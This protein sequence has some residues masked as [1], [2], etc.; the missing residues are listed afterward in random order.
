M[1][2][3]LRKIAEFIVKHFDAIANWIIAIIEKLV[4]APFPTVITLSRVMDY[5]SN[6]SYSSLTYIAKLLGL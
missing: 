3:I 6:L 1:E 4:G 5:L 2:Q